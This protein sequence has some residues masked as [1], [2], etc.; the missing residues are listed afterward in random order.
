[1]RFQAILL[2]V[3]LAPAGQA[4]AGE[5][6]T[7]GV[8]YYFDSFDPTQKPWKPGYELNYEEVFKNYQF[9]EIIFSPNGAEMTVNRYIRNNKSDSE[10]YS[11]NRDGSLSTRPGG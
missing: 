6:F 9:Y 11:I 10:R 5:R 2:S 4:C 3:L 8:A 1:M 7:P